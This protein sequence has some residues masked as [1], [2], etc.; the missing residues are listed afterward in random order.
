MHFHCPTTL[1]ARFLYC[2]YVHLNLS[3]E[4]DRPVVLLPLLVITTN[5][6]VVYGIGCPQG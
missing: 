5:A 3:M 4:N 1:P 2:S 6:L